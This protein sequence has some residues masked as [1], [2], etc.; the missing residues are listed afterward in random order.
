[1][2]LLVLNIVFFLYLKF[3]RKEPKLITWFFIVLLTIFGCLEI[4]VS[5]STSLLVVQSLII[6]YY[7]RKS[8]I[9]HSWEVGCS[10]EHRLLFYMF[11][12]YLISLCLFSK[13][14]L[15]LLVVPILYLLLRRTKNKN[16]W[17]FNL[18]LAIFIFVYFYTGFKTLNYE[19]M[20]RVD[21]YNTFNSIIG[22]SFILFEYFPAS[23]IHIF[24]NIYDYL[25]SFEINDLLS[26]LLSSKR[27]LKMIFIENLF[28]CMNLY[29]VIPIA[30]YNIFKLGRKNV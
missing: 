2:V 17:Y 14:L 25:L 28:I 3:I 9:I 18:I 20:N 7:E 30:I 10:I 21:V 24:T 22:D 26:F 8:S 29:F 6:I 23:N 1:M 5:K 19:Y 27:L 13:L 11:S 12:L 4:F 16:E 15:V